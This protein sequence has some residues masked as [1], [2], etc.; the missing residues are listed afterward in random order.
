MRP[1]PLPASDPR[2][3]AFMES[4]AGSGVSLA[5]GVRA[6]VLRVS[7]AEGLSEAYQRN[8]DHLA[9]WGPRRNEDFFTVGGQTASIESRLALFTAG[10]DV[11]WVLLDEDRIVGVLTLSGIARGPF[12]SAHLGYWVDK[13][14]NGRGVGSAA[15]AYAV[16]AARTELGLHR[17]Q[18][19]TLHHNAASQKVLKRSGFEEIGLAP[20]YLKIGQ[21][22]QD[23]ILYQRIL[24]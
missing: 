7:D 1:D 4:L 5:A 24:F 6:R 15:V 21:T 19:A 11:P 17:L 10:S 20:A 23:H 16:G 13:D 12:L 8:R 18:A 3:C 2:I 22:W 14:Y 9:P